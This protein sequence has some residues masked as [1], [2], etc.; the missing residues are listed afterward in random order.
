MDEI[1]LN[2]TRIEGEYIAQNY[3]RGTV[4]RYSLYISS[5]CQEQEECAL[6]VMHDGLNEEEAFAL[7]KLA[8]T[9]K[10]PPCISLGIVAGKLPAKLEGGFERG[11]RMKNYDIFGP[12]YPN[13]VVEEFIPW[14]T[15][16]YR[17]S[18]SA[19]PD[20]HMTSGSSSGGISAWNMAWYRNDY[21]RRV[22]MGSPSFLSMGR[23]RE[24]PALIRKCETKPIRVFTAFSED[25]PDDYFGSSYCVADDVERALRFA[26][27]D[28]MSK[29]YPGEGHSSRWNSLE[30]ALERM[31]FLWENWE[32]EP[33]RVKKL[34]PR[35]EQVVSLEHQW[36]E[37]TEIFPSKVTAYFIKENRVMGEYVA[38]GEDIYYISRQGDKCK[39][40]ES[41]GRI[42]S[43]GIS[44]DHCF[45]YI[46]CLDRGCVY[47]MAICSDGR[48]EGKYL[49][50]TLHME[51]DF[52][53]PG[54]IDLCVDSN[55]RIFV[56]TELG[57]QCIRSFGLI[58]VILTLPKNLI[59]KRIAFG[60]EDSNYLYVD[61]G[62][63]IFRRMMKTPAKT[64]VLTITQPKYVSYYD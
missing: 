46:G 1:K 53:C 44:S 30:N 42:T 13:F 47:S 14:I 7:E 15:N 26:G 24:I 56:A 62:K 17:L 4:F 35:V 64:D 18:I 20:M 11:M 38:E 37:T 33:I 23:G 9:K 61:C 51:T 19:S 25:E 36:E 39:V 34:S 45:L 43:L 28:M 50:G 16:Q 54:A 41:M 27:Y 29:Y 31:E 59:P 60:G 52:C 55:D 6:C 57:I 10:A 40:A 12:E 22:Y 32:T 58:D 48:L 8:D 21:F 49:Q 2:G 3:F 63:K 5:I